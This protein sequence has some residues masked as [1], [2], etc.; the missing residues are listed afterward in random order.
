MKKILQRAIYLGA[1]LLNFLAPKTNNKTITVP[2]SKEYKRV[3]IDG[4]L[5]RDIILKQTVDTFKILK[6]K[7]RI[8]LLL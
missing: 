2:V 7:I 3:E 6:K 5:D 8:K 1:E 4:T